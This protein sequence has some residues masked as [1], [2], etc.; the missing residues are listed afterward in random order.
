[1]RPILTAL[2]LLFAAPA[3]AGPQV[4][5]DIAPVHSL[6]AAVM[7]G[8]GEPAMLLDPNA[9]PHHITLRP[10]QARALADAQAIFWIGPALTPWLAKPVASLPDTAHSVALSDVPGTTLIDL[11]GGKADPHSWLDPDNAVLW[12]R[13]IAET[14]GR[15]DPHNAARYTANADDAAAALQALNAEVAAQLAPLAGNRYLVAHDAYGYFFGHF[16]LQVTQAISDS[17][18]AA[19]TAARLATLRDS[20]DAAP[21]T[22]ALRAPQQSPAALDTLLAGTDTPQA[23]LDPLGTTLAPGPALYPDLLRGMADSI[24]TCAD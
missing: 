10:S 17:D 18:A 1:M 8:I 15:I 6:V 12:L 23:M 20:L 4:V 13:A 19:P 14:L 5:T 24:A 11:G 2:L 22:C 9:D 3:D 7:D 21:P 16:G